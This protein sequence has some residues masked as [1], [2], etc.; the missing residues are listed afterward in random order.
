MLKAGQGRMVFTSSVAGS[1]GLTNHEAIAAVKG[2]L[3]AMVRAA[4]ST[5]AQ[6]GLRANAVAPGLTDTR[7][8]ATVLDQ[9][10]FARHPLA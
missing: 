7:L 5:Y 3:E 9:K 2:G 6:R 10:P 8:G 1:Y 4:A